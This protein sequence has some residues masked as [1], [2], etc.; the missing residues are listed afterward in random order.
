[1]GNDVIK[2]FPTH[3]HSA[4]SKPSLLH[5]C[6]GENMCINIHRIFGYGEKRMI[7]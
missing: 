6:V 5:F 1:M 7:K 4:I 2:A 3:P